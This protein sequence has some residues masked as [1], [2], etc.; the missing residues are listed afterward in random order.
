MTI[1]LPYHNAPN[2]ED[3]NNL[4]REGNTVSSSSNPLRPSKTKNASSPF[5]GTILAFNDQ[6]VQISSGTGYVPIFRPQYQSAKKTHEYVRASYIQQWNVLST[7][8][9]AFYN[10]LRFGEY[11]HYLPSPNGGGGLVDVSPYEVKTAVTMSRNTNILTYSPYG[12]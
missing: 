9:Q 3:V 11:I 6:G 10:N 1:I 2:Y 7:S 5:L 4:L 12:Y 8:I